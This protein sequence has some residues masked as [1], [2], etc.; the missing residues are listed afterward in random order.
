[1]GI[2]HREHRGGFGYTQFKIRSLLAL[3]QT[4][5][6]ES[7][8]PSFHEAL[9]KPLKISPSVLSV[10]SVVNP[11]PYSHMPEA[12]ERFEDAGDLLGAFGAFAAEAGRESFRAGG[13]VGGEELADEGDLIGES[14]GPGQSLW[15]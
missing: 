1:V 12:S 5:P 3:K 15:F 9:A 8:M 7:T 13:G 6:S 2:N 11:A 4:S 10:S 14:V